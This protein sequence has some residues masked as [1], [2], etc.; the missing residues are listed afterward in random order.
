MS[1]V[2]S[3]SYIPYTLVNSQTNETLGQI[4][5][6]MITIRLSIGYGS[7]TPAFDALADSGSDRNLLP[8]RWGEIL[9]INFKKITSR[10]IRGIG[11]VHIKVYPARIN[12]WVVGEKYPTEAD[13]SYEQKDPLLGRKGFFD[14]FES[15]SFKEKERF[16][17]INLK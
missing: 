5:R 12:I 4:F 13:F 2:L 17:V 7:I 16:T 11:G 6:P 8:A 14:L 3:F 15:V 10:T 1:K 9:G